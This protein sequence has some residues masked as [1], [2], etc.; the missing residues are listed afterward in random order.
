MMETLVSQ[1]PLMIG[2]WRR[3]KASW[4]GCMG[5][6]CVVM[7]KTRC[8]GPKQRVESSRSNPSTML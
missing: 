4:G 2:R 5:R 1:D 3:Q 7:W 8:F 6:K